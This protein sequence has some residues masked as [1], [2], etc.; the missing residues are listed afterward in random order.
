MGAKQDELEKKYGMAFDIDFETMMYKDGR[1]L[2]K[3][4]SKLIDNTELVDIISVELSKQ[5]V[6]PQCATDLAIICLNIVD[7]YLA[8][9]K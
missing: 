9:N 7:N 1:P 5:M 6:N 4:Q 2:I 3:Q 8:K